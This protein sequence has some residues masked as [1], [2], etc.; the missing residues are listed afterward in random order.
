MLGRLDFQPFRVS[1][2]PWAPNDGGK[3]RGLTK[4]PQVD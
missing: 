1:L 4:Q 3:E 2:Q